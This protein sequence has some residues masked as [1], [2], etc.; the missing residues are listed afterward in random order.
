MVNSV[1]QIL[2]KIATHMNL[3]YQR[4]NPHDKVRFYLYF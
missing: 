2:Q 3:F 1:L 4:E